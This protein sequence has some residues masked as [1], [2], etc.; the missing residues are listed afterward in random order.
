MPTAQQG[1]EAQQPAAG[2]RG[3]G[4]PIFNEGQLDSDQLRGLYREPERTPHVTPP[5]TAPPARGAGPGANDGRTT[6]PETSG[7]LGPS[8]NALLA[9]P[10]SRGARLVVAIHR[11]GPGAVRVL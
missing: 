5:R 8:P 2:P 6:W 11:H 4:Y 3:G 9:Q 1:A 10:A 7:F